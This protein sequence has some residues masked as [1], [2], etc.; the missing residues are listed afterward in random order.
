M[1][2][3]ND[4][5]SYGQDPEGRGPYGVP[6]QGQDRQSRPDY[7]PTGQGA[8]GMGPGRPQNAH[9]RP[10]QGGY[11][12]PPHGGY[13]QPPHGGYGQPPQGWPQQPPPGDRYGTTPYEAY[14]MQRLE[15][16][17]K[18]RALLTATLVS[19][20]V[21]VVSAVPGFL[22]LGDAAGFRSMID[23]SIAEQGRQLSAD[24]LESIDQV[25]GIVTGMGMAFMA[26]WMLVVVGLYLLV[27]VGLRGRRNW[28]RVTGIVFAIL[29]LVFTLPSLFALPFM[30]GAG[31][32]SAVVSLVSVA[33]DIWW[34]VLAFNG[35]ISRY[36]EQRAL[37]S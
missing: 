17:P 32:F 13:G 6:P 2:E 8:Y 30:G 23:E 31:M 35:Q 29:A 11:G 22:M 14:G 16:P 34:L 27:Y 25:L 9:G 1:P 19:L 10:P 24:Q 28:A 18:Y 12:Q 5:P 36:L 37:M 33:V 15:E 21:Y 7:G 3:Q 20:A 26:F 4:R